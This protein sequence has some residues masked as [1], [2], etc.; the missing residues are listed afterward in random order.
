[1]L[2]SGRAATCVSG[3]DQRCAIVCSRGRRSERRGKGGLG[4]GAAGCRYIT[5][6]VCACVCGCT[7]VCARL[8]DSEM[9]EKLDRAPARKCVCVLPRLEIKHHHMLPWLMQFHGTKQCDTA[10]VSLFRERRRK[11][12]K[13]RRSRAG[14]PAD[15]T[16]T[17]C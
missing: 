10:R 15:A 6:D 16:H 9:R 17:L 12:C 3:E 11:K 13:G 4:R 2:L 5:V 8:C 1:M 7:C 14:L